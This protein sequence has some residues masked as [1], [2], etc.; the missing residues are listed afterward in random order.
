MECGVERGVECGVESK[1][2]WTIECKSNEVLDL[3]G[4][5][6]SIESILKTVLVYYNYR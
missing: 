4:S 6:L 3:E 2:E 1:V 5:F